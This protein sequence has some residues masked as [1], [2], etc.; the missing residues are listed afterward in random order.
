MSPRRSLVL[1]P[2]VTG[3]DGIACVSRLVVRAL[4]L[5]RAGDPAPVEVLS[6][7]MR[8]DPRL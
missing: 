1:T 4:E 8:Q 6:L 7:A 3:A 5:P 2:G